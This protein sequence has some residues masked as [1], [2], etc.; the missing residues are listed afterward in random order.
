MLIPGLLEWDIYIYKVF[1]KVEIQSQSF[2]E[3]PSEAVGVLEKRRNDQNQCNCAGGSP[4][5]S[6]TL[7]LGSHS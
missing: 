7:D 6:S 1:K 3:I 2:S 4:G 5:K